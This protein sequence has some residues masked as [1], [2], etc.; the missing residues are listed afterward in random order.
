MN[1]LSISKQKKKAVKYQKLKSFKV[2]RY[3]SE[4]SNVE[5]KKHCLDIQSNA[6]QPINFNKEVTIMTS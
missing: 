3:S 4:I 6:Q 5:D 1:K 2:N